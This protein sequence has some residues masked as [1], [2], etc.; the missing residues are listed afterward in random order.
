[1]LLLSLPRNGSYR[2]Y[3]FLLFVRLNLRSR[4]SRSQFYI[5]GQIFRIASVEPYLL[6][7]LVPEKS[8]HQFLC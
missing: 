8:K 7:Y 5:L 6:A 1:M 2:F 4:V 3:L